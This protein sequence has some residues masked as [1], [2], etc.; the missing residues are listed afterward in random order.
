M[1]NY[2]Q[3]L[4]Q[5]VGIKNEKINIGSKVFILIYDRKQTARFFVHEVG[6]FQEV[7][8]KMLEFKIITMGL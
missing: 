3:A 1:R 7:S 8:W 5:I 6:V 2:E 4:D